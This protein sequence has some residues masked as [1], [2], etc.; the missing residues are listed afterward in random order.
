[1]NPYLFT[2]TFLMMMSLLTSSEV[3]RF[4]QSALEFQCYQQSQSLLVA[5]EEL[6]ELGHLE[7]LRE[8]RAKQEVD[9][10]PP[11]ETEVKPKKN[12]SVRRAARL[13]INTA[14]P[15]NNSRLNLYKLKKGPHKKGPKEFD[16]YEVVARV[17]RELYKEAPFF[18]EVPGVECRILDKLLEKKEKTAAFTTPD[19]LSDLDL[20]DKTLQDVFYHM[21][22]GT[23]KSVSLLNYVTWDQIKKDSK[24]QNRKINLFAVD[25]LILRAIFPKGECAENILLHRE[26]IWEQILDQEAHRLERTSDQCKG[27]GKF[28]EDLKN[29]FQAILEREGLDPE[30]Y[31]SNVFDCT[32]GEPGTVI[33]VPDP[34][35]QKLHRE[36]YI[37]P[38]NKQ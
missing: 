25:P 1:M 19:Q 38:Q 18:Q 20:D 14:R 21:L 13:N 29:A 36:K 6:R 17:M 5:A 11:D 10:D 2:L 31:M 15:P 12:P 8:E 23:N 37:P 30:P 16:F 22:K 35:T 24:K 26:R 28:S 7:E 4:S 3:I 32:L 9:P 33:F 34:L 27:R